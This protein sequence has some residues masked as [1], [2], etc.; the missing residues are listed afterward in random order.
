M[1]IEPRLDNGIPPGLHRVAEGNSFIGL[2]GEF[3]L[4]SAIR[5]EMDLN[6]SIVFSEDQ[7]RRIDVIDRSLEWIE[8]RHCN[9][10]RYIVSSEIVG[11]RI[12]ADA[13][14]RDIEFFTFYRS[15]EAYK[16]ALGN[17]DTTMVLS[18]I[19]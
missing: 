2:P 7:I 17:D 8:S 5:R 15:M 16:N 10:V 19:P 13:F 14:G 9:C 4:H 12:F 6:S 3:E 11:V 1:G 18:P